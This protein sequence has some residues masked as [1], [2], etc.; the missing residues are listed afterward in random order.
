MELL[1]PMKLLN[2]QSVVTLYRALLH[3][4]LSVKTSTIGGAKFS[5]SDIS[6]ERAGEKG[7]IDRR[8]HKINY[9]ACECGGG[10]LELWSGKSKCTP[11]SV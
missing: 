10:K 3:K 6:V 11:L 1:Q 9:P 5:Q 4:R 2:F 7:I 8:H